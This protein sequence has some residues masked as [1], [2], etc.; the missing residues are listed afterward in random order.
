MFFLC[1][2]D[3]NVDVRHRLAKILSNTS[4]TSAA[5]GNDEDN[6]FVVTPNASAKPIEPSGVSSTVTSMS[7]SSMTTATSNYCDTPINEFVDPV[8]YEDFI[9]A[10]NS[11]IPHHLKSV[12]LFP[13]D[14]IQVEKYQPPPRTLEPISPEF[15]NVQ[16]SEDPYIQSIGSFTP[17]TQ[18]LVKKY[19]KCPSLL[20]L[21]AQRLAQGKELTRQEFEIDIPYNPLDNQPDSVAVIILSR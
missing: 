21:G 6:T 7:S 1:F 8:D 17:H 9:L 20:G 15:N 2:R 5:L 16:T 18:I 3:S 13:P 11:R 10:N 19:E 4:T 14:D 12:L